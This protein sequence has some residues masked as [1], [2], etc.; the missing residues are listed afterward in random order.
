MQCIFYPF[1]SYIPIFS[2]ALNITKFDHLAHCRI[3]KF[4][5]STL[6]DKN[7]SLD[8]VPP[9]RSCTSLGL[10]RTEV[11]MGQPIVLIEITQTLQALHVYH[12]R[13]HK[14]RKPK[15]A[16]AEEISSKKQLN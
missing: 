3:L 14:W 15:Q 11:L 7:R 2:T 6:C 8:N 12:N 9:D 1:H 5:V 13:L 16:Q 10:L 4:H